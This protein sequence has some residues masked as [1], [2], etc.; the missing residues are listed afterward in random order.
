MLFNVQCLYD[1]L[2]L[3]TSTSKEAKEYFMDMNRHRILF[4]Y[5]GAEDDS[6]IVLVLFHYVKLNV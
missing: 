4:R 3:G 5:S 6:S 1:V 2:G